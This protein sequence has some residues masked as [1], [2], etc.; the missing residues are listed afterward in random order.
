MI[1][2]IMSQFSLLKKK[3]TSLFIERRLLEYLGLGFWE[4]LGLGT[5]F[6]ASLGVL[7]KLYA[8]FSDV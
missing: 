4:S 7:F 6:V 2:I 1:S 5:G 3:I 8:C